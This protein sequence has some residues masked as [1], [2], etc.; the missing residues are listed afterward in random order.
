MSAMRVL[1]LAGALCPS[2]GGARAPAAWRAQQRARAPRRAC[3]PLASDGGDLL[4][5]ADAGRNERVG[6]LKRLF[7]A[8]DAAASDEPAANARRA[9]AHGVY[10]DL[11]LCR[12]SFTI[13]PHAQ[14]VLNVFQP[15]YVH[16][17]ESLIATRPPWLYAHVQLP[18]GLANLANDDYALVPGS[19]APLAGTLMRVVRADRQ[20]DARLRLVVQG[21]RRVRVLRAT[22][23][24]PFAR[25]DVRALPDAEELG[26]ELQSARV[27]LGAAAGVGGEHGVALARLCAAGAAA[28]A[29]AWAAYETA[30]ASLVPGMVQE[31]YYGVQGPWAP[32]LVPL[33][34]SAA[35]A[36]AD[37]AARAARRAMREV[38]AAQGAE[39]RARADWEADV[40]RDA[41]RLRATRALSSVSGADECAR[42]AELE[43]ELW[44]NLDALLRRLHALRPDKAGAMPVPSPMLGLLPP[45]PPEGWPADFRCAAAAAERA[46]VAREQPALGF[47]AVDEV[48]PPLRRAQRLS[49]VVW[50]LLGREGESRQPVLEAASIAE[51]LTLALWWIDEMTQAVLE[52]R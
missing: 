7:Y 14:L 15:E 2:T 10:A 37:E 4:G 30:D 38:V 34:A 45:T 6:E 29:A 17:F 49:Y 12:W 36:C 44:V 8:P 11:A 39:W 13:L 23:R 22:Q 21:L 52:N 46:D 24:L 20:S 40:A 5:G 48:Y 1:L 28:R 41:E 32:P 25:A 50:D 35:G 19:K 33:N 47:V 18:G 43:R 16:L 26:A 3:R 42:L 9:R 27:E 51:R 31:R